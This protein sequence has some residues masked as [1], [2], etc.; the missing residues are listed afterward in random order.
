MKTIKVTIKN[1]SILTEASGYTG[2]AC[3]KPLQE[4]QDALGG[5]VLKET[6]TDEGLLPDATI[7]EENTGELHA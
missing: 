4:M 2:G 3:V 7:S 1:G 6:V 5:K